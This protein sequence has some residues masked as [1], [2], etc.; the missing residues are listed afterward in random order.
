MFRDALSFFRRKLADDR[1]RFAT[2]LIEDTLVTS[3]YLI[4]YKSSFTSRRE[5]YLINQF[6]LNSQVFSPVA[7]KQINN[8]LCSISRE[9]LSD[10]QPQRYGIRSILNNLKR[11][12]FREELKNA[13]EVVDD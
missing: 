4:D 1:A 7:L 2:D 3:C 5:W 8:A 10:H 12:N 11:I 9:V 6:D 13:C